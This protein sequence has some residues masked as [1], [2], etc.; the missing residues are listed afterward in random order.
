ML[1]W[2]TSGGRSRDCCGIWGRVRRRVRRRIGSRI[3]SRIRCGIRSRIRSRVGGRVR[4][5]IAC[6]F[7]AV[8]SERRAAASNA[9]VTRLAPALVDMC[10]VS[11]VKARSGVGLVVSSTKPTV[12]GVVVEMLRMCW[13]DPCV[14]V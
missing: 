8:P 11:V 14:V 6:H 1:G 13:Y 2:R 10:P 3:R 4:R 5:R 12:C 9:V 7:T